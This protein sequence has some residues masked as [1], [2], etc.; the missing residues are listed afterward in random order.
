[1]IY[2]FNDIVITYNK[3]IFWQYIKILN[4]GK[5][6]FLEYKTIFLHSCYIGD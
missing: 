5:P 1:M 6:I 3:L 2:Q 4:I